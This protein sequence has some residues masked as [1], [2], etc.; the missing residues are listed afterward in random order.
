MTQTCRKHEVAELERQLRHLN[1]VIETF[2]SNEYCSEQLGYT[3]TDENRSGAIEI[4]VGYIHE[5]ASRLD[6]LLSEGK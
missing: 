6:Y 2:P 5:A 1:F 3:F 4:C